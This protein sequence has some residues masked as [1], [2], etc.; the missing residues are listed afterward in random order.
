MRAL[1]FIN[2]KP[3]LISRPEMQHEF[4]SHSGW[5]HSK[6][7]QRAVLASLL[8]RRSADQFI[9]KCDIIVLNG[10][11]VEEEAASATIPPS[12]LHKHLGDLLQ[13]GRGTDV[14]FEVGGEAF[15][16]HRCVL[17]ARSPVISADLLGAAIDGATAAGVVRVDGVE[18]RAFR[19]LLR[20]AYIDSLPEMDKE[21]EDAILRNLLVAVDRYGLQRLK[22]ICEDKVCKLLNVATVEITL[23]LAEQ[24]HCDRLK[25]ACLQFLGA[26]AN[27]RV[28]GEAFAAHRCV[29]AAQSPV[30]SADLLSAEIDGAAVAGVVR[31]DGVDPR[32]F[33]A[34][35]R[36][37][38]TDSLPEMDNEEED[39]I[40]RNL[41]VAAD[42]YGLQRLK[43][44]CEDKLCW[45]LNVATVEITLALAEQHHCDRLKEA[46]LQFLGAPANLRAVMGAR[47]Q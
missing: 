6:F 9:V 45:L 24:H 23:A 1:F 20:Y 14:V 27:L 30:I 22:L 35:L 18:P 10:F 12:D 47:G 17:A 7:E 38:Y 19:A 46:C 8:R 28:G 11:R 41:L 32:A 37:A 42:R 2:F 43:L 13:S 26:P 21:E 34:L 39:A 31:V 25:E 4:T 15:A 3:G 36:Y 5:G 29:L 16:A 40:L 33:R 44:I